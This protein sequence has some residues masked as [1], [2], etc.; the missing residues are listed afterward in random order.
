MVRPIRI[1][2]VWPLYH[3]T[4]RGDRREAIYVDDNDRV[5]FLQFVDRSMHRAREDRR[6]S[7][8][9]LKSAQSDVCPDRNA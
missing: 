6:R 4:A 5:A 1:E 9:A 3:V 7:R 8:Q 2:F